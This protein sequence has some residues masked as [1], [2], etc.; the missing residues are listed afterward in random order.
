MLGGG[1]DIRIKNVKLL[2][3][4]LKYLKHLLLGNSQIESSY[5]TL[6]WWTHK[7]AYEISDYTNSFLKKEGIFV[8]LIV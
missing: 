4:F 8:V 3:L 2:I 1:G 7:F 6:P 5:K